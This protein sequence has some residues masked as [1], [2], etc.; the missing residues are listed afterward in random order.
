MTSA[1][2]SKMT[3]S[4]FT[5]SIPRNSRWSSS[6]M[7]AGTKNSSISP[8][9]QLA[10]RWTLRTRS[11]RVASNASTSAM[12]ITPPGTG[13]PKALARTWPSTE[14]RTIRAICSQRLR[15]SA[16]RKTRAVR[17]LGRDIR[18]VPATS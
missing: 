1:V 18:R 3:T 13:R 7:T 8:S 2:P 9:S 4:S 14:N 16:R 5:P 12:P 6:D 11:R 10:P 15:R 17:G